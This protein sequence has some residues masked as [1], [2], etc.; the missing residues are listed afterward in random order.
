LPTTNVC[1][2]RPA[3]SVSL[4]LFLRKTRRAGHLGESAEAG[5]APKVSRTRDEAAVV[6]VRKG[7]V[8]EAREVPWAAGWPGRRR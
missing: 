6:A 7:A 2:L 8:A 3:S 1:W 5:T 4:S